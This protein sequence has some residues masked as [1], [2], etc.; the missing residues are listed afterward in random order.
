MRRTVTR[1]IDGGTFLVSHKLWDTNRV[2]LVGVH[3]PKKHQLG[4][5]QATNKLKGLIGGK[6]V[7]IIPIGI[8]SNLVI[9]AVKC[10]KALINKKMKHESPH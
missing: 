6:Q 3:T 1:V 7:T 2:R 10:N 5:S 4:G 8:D 9:A